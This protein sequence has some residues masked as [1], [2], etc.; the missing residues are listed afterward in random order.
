M[1]TQTGNLN[2]ARRYATA[3]Y[4]LAQEQGQIDAVSQDLQSLS[5]ILAESSDF[6]RFIS[7]A[8]LQRAD[9]ARAL[10]AIGSKAA[11]CALTQKFLG[12]LA[13]KRR[14]NVLPQIIAA[15]QDEIAR[16]RGEVTAEVT[17]AFALS[18]AQVSGIAAA[19]KKNLGLTVKVIVKEDAAIMGGLVI[20]I[21]SRRIDSSV[22][23]KLER[24]HRALKSANTIN[25][26]T[27]M[28]EVA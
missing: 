13:M 3:Y 21:G 4:G 28:R 1:S 19:L 11:F 14:L 7:N 2:V 16:H 18:P 5:R 8:T 26:K 23:S 15:M 6:L 25:N 20:T 12:S 9:Q 24:L 22:K 10:A 17:A 27:K